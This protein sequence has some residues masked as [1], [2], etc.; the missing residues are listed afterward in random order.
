MHAQRGPNTAGGRGLRRIAG[1]AAA[2]TLLL[3]GA[4]PLLIASSAPAQAEETAVP[5]EQA[6]DGSVETPSPSPS[7]TSTPIPAPAP[8]TESPG[9]TMGTPSTPGTEPSSDPATPSPSET[10]SPSPSPSAAPT[11]SATPVPTPK[12]SAARAEMAPMALGPD[13]PGVTPPYVYWNLKDSQSS[14]LVGGATFSIQGPRTGTS[15]DGNANGWTGAA[16]SVVDNTGQPGYSGLDLDPD[17]GEFAVKGLRTT[18]SEQAVRATARYRV[19]QTAAP[20]GYSTGFDQTWRLIPAASTNSATPATTAWVGQTYDFGTFLNDA[21]LPAVITVKVGADRTGVSGVTGL[22]GVALVLNTGTGSPSGTRPDGVAGAGPGWARCVSDA[23]GDCVF[24]VPNTEVGGA[25]R[26]QRYWVVQ[27][28]VPSGWYANP[29]LRTGGPSGDGIAENYVFRT[30]TLLRSGTTYSSTSSFMYSTSD[31][32]STASG[33]IWQ[34]SRVN[35]AALQTCGTDIALVLDLSGSVADSEGDLKAAASTFVNALVGTQSR[36]SLFSFSWDSPASGATQNYPTLTPVATQ[37]QADAFTARY[38]SWSAAGGTNWDRGLATVASANTPGNRFAVTVV[39]TDGNPTAFG[40]NTGQ[41]G[42]TNRF[43]E[44]ENGIF[45]ANALKA[46]GSRVIAFGVGAGANGTNTALNLRAISGPTKGSDYYQTTDYASVG[47]TLRQLALGACASNVTVTKMI[48]PGTAAPGSIAGATPAPAGWRF[49]ASAADSGVTLP[50]P[51][52]RT[53]IADGTGTV[54]FPLSFGAG[55]ATGGVT[56]TETQQPGYTLVPVAGH[57]AVCTN[58]TT[59]AAVVPKQDPTNGFRIDAPSGQSVNCIVYNRAPNPAATVSATKTWIVKDAGGG[60]QT[61]HLPGDEQTLP[62]GLS[63][64]LTLQAGGDPGPLN[65]GWGVPRSGLQQGATVTLGE[66]ASVDPAKLPGCTLTSQRVTQRN[67]VGVTAVLPYQATLASGANTFEL[68]N[69]VT[70]TSSLTLVKLVSNTHGGTGAVADWTLSGTGTGP[71][72]NSVTGT[73]GATGTVAPGDYTL[74][75][76]GGPTGYQPSAWSCVSGGSPVPAVLGIVHVE[77]GAKVTC[78]V[79]NSDLPGA[80]K[81]SKVA[82]G[83]TDLLAGSVWRIVGPAPSTSAITVTDCTGSPCTGLDTDATAGRFALAGLAWG[84]Y[85]ATETTAPPGYVGGATFTFAVNAANAGT[86]I[87]RGAIAN[88]PQ[89]GVA[90]PLSGG[91]STDA[92]MIAGGG[93]AAIAAIVAVLV[94][95][96]TRRQEADA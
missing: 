45:S 7:P 46:S 39:I 28:S 70:C 94:W 5:A 66:N 17:P 31:S 64:Q 47:S 69:E 57:N 91:S 77:R 74:S 38:A 4:G 13:G 33:G 68:T 85:T 76:S 62:A 80:V 9:P 35:P 49:D 63:G 52:D 50:S 54:A 40:P 8:A 78:T 53:T 65:Q 93:T 79:T 75:E 24:N 67:G 55:V 92:F 14:A 30:G 84:S 1:L 36:M 72:A 73:S 20:N 18:G 6:P 21:I 3:L 10:P 95:R 44:T 32:L 41:G 51:A 12:A 87:D 60:S 71:G 26:D 37:A 96:R 48:V 22:A 16:V 83:T 43:V 27:Q 11:P 23:N 42:T 86:V 90:L 56:F 25:N 2:T 59:N 29:Q 15:N 61:F 34:Q 88:T 82:K 81:W 89:P 58:L 19:Q